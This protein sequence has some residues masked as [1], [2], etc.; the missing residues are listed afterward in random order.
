M[1]EILDHTENLHTFEQIVPVCELTQE[2]L[3]KLY[4]EQ[5]S[6]LACPSCG[7]EPFLG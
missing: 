4:E 5:Q 3:R 2:E 1:T 6:R 7:E